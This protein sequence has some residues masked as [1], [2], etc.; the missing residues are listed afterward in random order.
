MREIDERIAQIAAHS[1][2]LRHRALRRATG[3]IG[4]ALEDKNSGENRAQCDDSEG[5]TP[6]NSPWPRVIVHGPKKY[7][8]PRP[9]GREGRLFPPEQSWKTSRPVDELGVARNKI[10][11]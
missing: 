6:V 4:A 11:A 5:Q 10:L 3:Q 1:F 7:R 9:S 2:H 8:P